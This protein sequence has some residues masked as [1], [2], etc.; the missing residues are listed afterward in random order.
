MNTK[1]LLDRKHRS[2]FTLLMKLG[3]FSLVMSGTSFNALSVGV[4][5]WISTFNAGW[6][7]PNNGG[8]IY[9]TFGVAGQSGIGSVPSC[10][11]YYE[12][13]S[14]PTLNVEFAAGQSYYG[15][16]S[17]IDSPALICCPVPSFNVTGFPSCAS[18]YPR[19]WA[20]CPD[21]EGRLSTAL[22]FACELR[23]NANAAPAVQWQ[24]KDQSGWR[25]ASPP[26]GGYYRLSA[27]GVSLAIATIVNTASSVTF[28]F[29]DTNT[30]GCRISNTASGNG[31]TLEKTL[32]TRAETTNLSGR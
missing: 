26:K 21:G 19:V 10:S 9:Y 1:V 24:V 11:S 23:Y 3:L 22:N 25:D 27:D 6:S 30:L 4:S 2:H 15:S 14:T 28:V 13:Y 7:G 5:A 18:A 20:W 16:V 31:A 32:D 17:L 12:G 8:E 29:A